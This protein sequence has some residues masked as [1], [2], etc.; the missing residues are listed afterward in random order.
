MGELARESVRM[1][2]LLI[3]YLK[4]WLLVLLGLRY[5]G[6]GVVTLSP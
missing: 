1:N 6:E 3:A 4:R 2:Y 5:R